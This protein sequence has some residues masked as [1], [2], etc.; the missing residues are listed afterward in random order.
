MNES[1][2]ILEQILQ[3]KAGEVEAAEQRVSLEDLKKQCAGLSPAA[4]FGKALRAKTP[5]GVI[6]EI[7]RQSPSRGAIRADLDPVKT[8]QDFA[9]AGAT[10][11]SILTDEKFFG[12]SLDFLRKVK[13]AVPGV[14]VLR[15]DF[16]ISTYQVWE[17]RAAGAD[18]ILLIVA[19]LPSEQLLDLLTDSFDA[20]LDV[21]I[22]AHTEDELLFAYETVSQVAM[23]RG[24][25]SS[26]EVL[27]G[28]NN[29]DLKTFATD[30]KVSKT[31]FDELQKLRVARGDSS[32]LCLVSESGIRTGADIASLTRSGVG[33]FLVGESLLAAGEPGENL[34]TLLEEAVRNS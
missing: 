13:A 8:A 9:K 4:G 15:K 17:T 2:S 10:C 22:E 18:A 16:I 6:A 1:E 34:K 19:A 7:K 28:V 29:R 33:A 25:G 3:E 32:P 20:G 27:L 12:G 5:F 31:L 11:L 21:L 14:P 23:R 30:L 26:P 24:T